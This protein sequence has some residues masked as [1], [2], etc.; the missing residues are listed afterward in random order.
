MNSMTRALIV[1]GLSFAAFTSEPTS[2]QTK[3]SPPVIL[4]YPREESS[5]ELSALQIKLSAME[6]LRS[7]ASTSFAELERQGQAL[8][9]Q[10]HGASERVQIYFELAH[11]YAQSGIGLHPD[12]VTRY[13]RSALAL[14][15]DPIQRSIL[16]SYLGS[17]ACVDPTRLTFAEQRAQAAPAWL[18]GYK[19]LLAFHLPKQAPEMPPVEKISDAAPDEDLSK[20]ELQRHAEQMKARK[21][22]ERIRALVESRDIFVRQLAEA[23]A[24]EPR[25]DD[26]IKRL[27]KRIVGDKEATR[28]LLNRAFK[29]AVV[30][31]KPSGN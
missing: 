15:K 20:Q 2:G 16:Y 12:R 14:E 29:L 22:A 30:P 21:K 10:F 1:F 31:N 13:A 6:S 3:N 23:Y 5:P 11:V 7:G 18:Q 19:E 26:E 4:D 8:L 25:N 17:A 28:L 24:R 9:R 27:A